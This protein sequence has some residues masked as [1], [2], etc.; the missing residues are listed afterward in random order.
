MQT[1]N[2]MLNMLDTLSFNPFKVTLVII[3]NTH[4]HRNIYKISKTIDILIIS[5]VL[6]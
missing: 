3:L 1:C 2:E 5:L 4:I 6:Q